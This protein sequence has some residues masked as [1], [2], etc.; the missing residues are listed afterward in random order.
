MQHSL[1][2][3]KAEDRITLAAKKGEAVRIATY[4]WVNGRSEEEIAR[5]IAGMGGG[6]G[7]R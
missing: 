4:P 6:S 7:G 5:R 2:P 1:E 3:G